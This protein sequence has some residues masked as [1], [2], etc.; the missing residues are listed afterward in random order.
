M[1]RLLGLAAAGIVGALA[2]LVVAAPAAHAHVTVGAPAA[3]AGGYTVLTFRAPTESDTESTV[4]LH[5]HLPTDTPL[6]SVRVKP[7]P[8][9]SAQLVETEL[10]EPVD[11]PHGG[12]VTHAVTEIV[13]TATDGGL[14]PQEFGEF[15]VSVGP[16][17]DVDV[18]FFPTV[19]TYSDGREVGWV[20]QAAA[21]TEAK[22]PAPR[23]E[24]APATGDGHGGAAGDAEGDAGHA[25]AAGTGSAGG[26]AAG[27]GSAGG[28]AGGAPVTGLAIAALV[29][30]GLALVV[31][32]V[33]VLRRPRA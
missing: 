14:G 31:S 30:A 24:I 4:G 3:E 6:L 12:T 27:A 29:A 16:L 28:D 15:S 1:R 19:Q 20:E 23:L 26:D 33:S 21:G 10:P 17:P 2:L 11:G 13:W 8:G 18:L 9:W 7:V 32:V 5:V 25:D 22:L